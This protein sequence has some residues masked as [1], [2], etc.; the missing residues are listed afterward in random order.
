MSWFIFIAATLLVLASAFLINKPWSLPTGEGLLSLFVLMTAQIIFSLLLAGAVLQR[1]TIPVVLLINALFFFIV[2][3]VRL[4]Q[5]HIRRA[6]PCCSIKVKEKIKEIRGN[7]W[8]LALLFLVTGETGWLT[9]LGYLFPPYDWDGLAYHLT[10]VAAW[11]EAAKITLTPHSLWANVYPLNTELIF[12]WNMLFLGS[13]II[14][15]LT[16]LG[17]ALAGAGAVAALGNLASLKT[18][19]KVVAGSLFFLTP[20][21][22]IQSKTAYVDV[23]L[24]S[25][26]LISFY[27]SYRYAQ[28]PRN[29]Y[30]WLAGLGSGITLGMKS[31]AALYVTV[32]TLFILRGLGKCYRQRAGKE[33]LFYLKRLG[34]FLFLVSLGGSF[35][36]LRTWYYYGNP[37]YPFTVEIFGYTLFPGS[38]QVESLIMQ[39]NTPRE[40]RNLPWYQQVW[41]SWQETNAPYVYDQLLGGFGPQWLYLEFPSLVIITLKAL[42]QR[43][44]RLLSLFIPFWV[45]FVLHPANWWSRYTI[46]FVAAGALALPLLEQELPSWLAQPLRVATLSLVLVSLAGSFT[47]TYFSPQVVS[48]FLALPP[49]K[50]TFAE[51]RPWGDELAWV[52]EVPPGSRIGY[53]KT[54]FPYLLYGHHL[55]NRVFRITPSSRKTFYQEILNLDLQ[56]I[57]TTKDSPAAHWLK[58]GSLGFHPYFR[59]GDYIVFRRMNWEGKGKP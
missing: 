28:D 21:I 59:Y 46:F 15:D 19:G 47:H 39:P 11:I 25:M 26:F 58:Q 48:R 16:Q 1:L 55:R 13:D 2:L 44:W 50:R 14:V 8:A 38:G 45:L 24:A 56:Y 20:I 23:A 49:E 10:A 51:L 9:F 36:Y 41:I 43:S 57:F 34:L 3:L 52:D 53:T 18:P 29:V 17:F 37:F 31:S 6:S 5:G 30:L 27:F 40:L 7:F 32:N 35:W 4:R 54:S 12:T 42:F 33:S 22:L